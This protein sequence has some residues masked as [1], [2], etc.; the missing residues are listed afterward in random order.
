[1]ENNNPIYN[2][3]HIAEYERLLLGLYIS[4][5]TIG[6]GITGPAF[7]TTGHRTIFS[8]I[9]ELKNIGL[10]LNIK[11]LIAELEK[12]GKLDEAGGPA[13]IT[14]LTDG[15]V[16]TA[17]VDFYETEILTA[18]RWRNVRKAGEELQKALMNNDSPD[19]VI[20]DTVKKLTSII[21]ARPHK[22]IG[23]LI[24]ELLITPFPPDT[25]FVENL[26]GPGLTVLTGAA[27]VGKS[28]TAL[29]LATALD[30]GG[31]FMDKLKANQCD[32]LYMALEDTQKRIQKRLLKQG[33]HAAFNG[34]RIETTRCTLPV[35]RTFLNAN[36]QIKV[37]VI[38]TLQKMLNMDD[39]NAYN[40]TVDNL[41]KLKTIADDLN[42]AIVVIHH[43]RK[44]G[45]KDADHMESA[46]GSTGINAT[47][48][49]T[50]TLRRQRGT[51]EA[52][53]SVTGRDVEDISYSLLW[54]RELCTYSISGQG[55]LK[56]ALPKELQRMVDLLK[57]DNREW[58]TKEI[59]TELNKKAPTISEQ[60]GKLADLGYI[61]KT[62]TG[63]WRI[64]PDSEVRLP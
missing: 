22:N 27:K 4:G 64:K 61:D 58:A 29:S 34:S 33:N 21:T 19:Q 51:S 1:M 44:G 56:Q 40:E 47:A 30:Q 6:E 17:N 8:I 41:S 50:L 48:D 37:V 59:A 28:W 10:D 63:Y 53:L 7:S 23:T 52:T 26:I 24:S 25:W 13:Y 38:D 18:H 11:I 36:R 54:D 31:Y 60:A 2:S 45:N 15:A 14:G 49:C 43:N 3:K 39:V 35:L 57:S 42:I 16:S 46:L 62:K 9:R 55:P 32:V 5:A 20:E 12:K